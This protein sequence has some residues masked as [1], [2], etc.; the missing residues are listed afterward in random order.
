M[1]Q[2]I[3]TLNDIGKAVASGIIIY[4]YTKLREG[5][6]QESGSKQLISRMPDEHAQKWRQ[7]AFYGQI[8]KRIMKRNDT[9]D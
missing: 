4:E 1:F 6:K 5:K 2:C 7:D 9:I 3:I 8:I